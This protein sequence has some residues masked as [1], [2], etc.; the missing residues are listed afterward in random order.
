MVLVMI[1]PSH[2]SVKRYDAAKRAFAFR[3]KEF[4]FNSDLRRV[5]E[6]CQDVVDLKRR[7][8]LYL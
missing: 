5:F 2:A 4:S 8:R 1:T 6:A 3:K 7:L